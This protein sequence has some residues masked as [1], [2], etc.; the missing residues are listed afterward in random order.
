MIEMCVRQQDGIDALGIEWKWLP[1]QILPLAPTLEESTI[2]QQSQ[3]VNLNKMTR[4]SNH[5]RCTTKRDLHV[6]HL[7]GSR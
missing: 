2:Q 7:L 6:F 5:L 3:S 4:A 1:V